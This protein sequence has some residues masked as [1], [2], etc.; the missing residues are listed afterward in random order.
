MAMPGQAPS[1]L[2][3]RMEAPYLLLAASILRVLVLSSVVSFVSI[4]LS[5]HLVVPAFAAA[6]GHGNGHGGNGGEGNGGGNGNGQGNGNGNGGG[7]GQ[8]NSDG[9]GNQ[10]NGN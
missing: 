4:N 7:N 1:S 10:G 9:G 5:D 8:G 3:R 2:S 6:G